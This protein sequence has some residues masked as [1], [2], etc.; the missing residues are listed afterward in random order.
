[1]KKLRKRQKLRGMGYDEAVYSVQLSRTQTKAIYQREHDQY[2]EVFSIRKAKH[3]RLL[4]NGMVLLAGELYPNNEDFGK[5]A[6]CV[7][8]KDRAYEIYNR[9]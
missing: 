1:M 6:W 5:T 4:P 3:G 7:K 2:Y 8:D 9:L